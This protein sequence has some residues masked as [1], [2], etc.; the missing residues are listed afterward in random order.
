ME[1]KKGK[2]TKIKFHNLFISNLNEKDVDH[3]TTNTGLYLR[4]KLD[5]PYKRIA[6]KVTGVN[7]INQASDTNQTDEEYFTNLDIDKIP[8]ST[9]N[10]DNKKHNIIVERYPK[11]EPGEPYIFICNHTCPEDIETVLNILDRNAYLVL[12]SVKTL[13]EELDGYLVW[14]NGTIP[15]DISNPKEKKTVIPKASRVLKTNSI[16]IFPEASHNLHPNK[17]VNN[18]YDGAVNIALNTNRKIVPVSLIRDSKNNVSYVDVS[19]PIDIN[20]LNNDLDEKFS[21]NKENLPQYDYNKKKIKTM[22]G[23]LRDKMATSI[24]HILLRHD[25]GLER[26]KYNNIESYLRT[27]KIYDSIEKLHWNEYDDFKGEFKTKKTKEE[28]AQ[29]TIIRDMARLAS[30]GKNIGF[31]Q[32]NWINLAS[33]QENKNIPRV[34]KEYTKEYKKIR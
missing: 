1:L 14:L 8:L 33:D 22:T 27:I 15:F 17:L 7:I 5:T 4:K 16:L 20:K 26:K 30:T 3:F 9:Y 10:L 23:T 19:N 12:G 21:Y 18:F 31:N 24:M 6:H 34:V 29:E 32:S 25:E 28:Q 11:L 2:K 13:R